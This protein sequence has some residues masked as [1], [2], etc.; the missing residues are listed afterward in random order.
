MAIAEPASATP[1]A[2]EPALCVVAV[3]GSPSDPS[4]SRAVAEV[5]LELAGGE[6]VIDLADLDPAAL[7]AIGS[8]PG[9]EA[10]CDQVAAA[11][12]L[13]V[14]T[15]VYRATYTALT[16][17][18]F[19]LLPQDA[20]AGTVVVPIATGY[21]A[22]H[23]LAIDHGIRPLI[24]SLGGWTTPTGVYATKA[25]IADDGT[26]S[27]PLRASVEAAVTEAVTLARALA[28]DRR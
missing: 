8:D 27:G 14:A 20:L 4:R 7:L 16:K 1:P 26:L 9:V 23:R 10:A 25:D 3:N 6:V 22:D 2:E 19:D 5:A 21:I 28:G 12:V 13:I 15:P 24:A 11:D 17:T 18:I